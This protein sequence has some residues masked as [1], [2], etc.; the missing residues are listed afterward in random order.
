M[1]MPLPIA[2]PA[3]AWARC[4]LQGTN[5]HAL[6]RRLQGEESLTLIRA[7]LPWQRRRLWLAPTVSPLTE[8][9]AIGSGDTVVTTCSVGAVHLRYL[10]DHQARA[11]TSEPC[12]L[13][14]TRAD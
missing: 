12:L 9:G 2:P 10:W 14:L 8:R 1:L 6:V 3:N 7:Q 4:V 13:A 11:A 5:A